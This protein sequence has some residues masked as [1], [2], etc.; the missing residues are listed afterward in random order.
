LGSVSHEIR[1]KVGDAIKLVEKD[2]WAVVNV[3]GSHRQY[4][5]P[6]KFMPGFPFS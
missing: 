3:E 4:K 5:H 6:A 1:V 2:G